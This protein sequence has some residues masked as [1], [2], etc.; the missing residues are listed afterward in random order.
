LQG[1]FSNFA[2]SP[3]GCQAE[4]MN[5]ISHFFL[6]RERVKES[7]FFVGISTPDLVSV[8]D[9]NI[10]LRANRMPVLPDPKADRAGHSFYRGVLRHFEGD[11]VFHSSTFFQQETHRICRLMEA[12][13][14]AEQLERTFFVAH[15]L[16]ELVLDKVLIQE[17]GSLLPDFYETIAQQEGTDLIRLTE[18]VAGRPLPGYADFL[19]RFM[20]RRYLYRYTDWEYVIYIL[21]R[22]M[23]GVGVRSVTYLGEPAFLSLAARYEAELSQRCFPAM[24]RLNEALCEV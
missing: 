24:A 12:T 14:P 19:E 23:L 4:A 20:T 15:I 21:R 18:W 3:E 22:I 10:R 5:F 8:F 16:F 9:R 11:K 6:D 17:D 7:L 1:N 2:R 13:I